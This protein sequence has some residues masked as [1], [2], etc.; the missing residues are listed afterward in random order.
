MGHGKN[1]F[2]LT[3][4]SGGHYDHSTLQCCYGLTRARWRTRNTTQHSEKIVAVRTCAAVPSSTSTVYRC[5]H[6]LPEMTIAIACT[7]LFD[8]QSGQQFLTLFSFTRLP[9][10]SSFAISTPKMTSGFDMSQIAKCL[11][12]LKEKRGKKEKVSICTVQ[13]NFCTWTVLHRDPQQEH[14]K[15]R[16]DQGNLLSSSS[17]LCSNANSASPQVDIT[18]RIQKLNE[19]VGAG[20]TQSSALNLQAARLCARRCRSF[21]TFKS[22]SARFSDRCK[23]RA[24]VQCLLALFGLLSFQRLLAHA[25]YCFVCS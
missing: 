19:E 17:V 12:D 22:S 11:D 5:C 4:Q 2:V 16:E 24:S 20:H 1:L 8:A 3:T 13:L 6:V 15:G 14:S 10:E 21:V 23:Q 9:R 18:R 7:I 25:W